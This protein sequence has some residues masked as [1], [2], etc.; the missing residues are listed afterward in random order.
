MREALPLLLA[1]AAAVTAVVVAR[2]GPSRESVLP[3]SRTVA[4]HEK[5]LDRASAVAFPLSPEEERAIGMEM[6]AAIPR[7]TP[8]AGSTD[9]VH[10]AQWREAA[11]EAARSPLVKRFAGRYEFRVVQEYSPNAFAIPGGFVFAT[12]SLL[13]KLGGDFDALMFVAGHEIGH[14]ELGHTADAY[15]LQSSSSRGPVGV[16][17]G[18]VLS[19]PR[20]FASLHFSQT[21]EL[22]ADA[23]AAAVMRSRGRDPRAGLRVF[24]ALGIPKDA[25]TKRG[26]DEIAVE[27]LSDYFRTHPGGWERR[28]AL[29][30]AIAANQ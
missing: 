21:Q 22:E 29:E 14:I 18:G 13:D 1:A 9:A 4:E 10:E 3:L 30:K 8:V 16:V 25:N 7:A 24:D 23:Y 27:G 2:S 28:A 20:L 26:P 15:R 19:I 5:G 17:V 12:S 11:G 6:A